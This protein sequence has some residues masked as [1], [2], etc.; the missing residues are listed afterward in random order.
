[1]TRGLALTVL[2]AG[3]IAAPPLAAQTAEVRLLATTVAPDTVRFGDRFE[4]RVEVEVPTD[5]TLYAPDY[6][7]GTDSV[8][9][10]A[11]FA[12][13]ERPGA[14]GARRVTLAFPL[15]AYQVGE[16]PL[17][18]VPLAVGSP[19]S[20]TSPDGPAPAALSERAF[21]P[22]TAGDA[23]RTVVSGARVQVT[24]ILGA[25]GGPLEPR[26]PDDVVGSSWSPLLVLS[27]LVFGTMLV[28][29]TVVSGRDW[30][31]TRE[32]GTATVET[33]T[34]D[35]V[36]AARRRALAELDRLLAAGVEG[37]DE[38]EAFYGT[39]SDA[40]RRYVEILDPAWSDAYTSSEL[41]VALERRERSN[42]VLAALAIAMRTAE[43]VKFG[44]L[45]PAPDRAMQHGAQLRRWVEAS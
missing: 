11:P 15:V 34:E 1:M 14:D 36:T 29:V 37:P 41:M 27:A 4:L 3:A 5:R 19:P 26:P 13:S 35:P 23:A 30:L 22:A 25:E 28:G 9:S 6:L 17:P 2:L 38:V 10:L 44:R 40:V 21:D 45:R 16:T 39:A 33:P 32:A 42:E 12:W 43:R 24:S 20:G 31:A 8:E 7:V 18:A